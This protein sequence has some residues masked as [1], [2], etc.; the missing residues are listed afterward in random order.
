MRPLEIPIEMPFDEVIAQIKKFRSEAKDATGEVAGGLE[1][2][3][4]ATGGA[5]RGVG[6]LIEG[7]AGFEMVKEGL[8]LVSEVAAEIGES[9]NKAAEF[10]RKCAEEFIQVQKGMQGIAA[11]SGRQ[12][13]DKFTMEQ[14]EKA[15]AAHLTPQEFAKSEE[16][17]LERSRANIG[18]GPGARMTEEEADKYHARMAEFAKLNKVDAGTMAEFA[19][20]LLNQQKGPVTADELTAQ[21]GKVFETLRGSG[22][23]I[24]AG[25]TSLNRLM[26]QGV[27]AQ[28][29]A[30]ALAQMGQIGLGRNDAQTYMS[31]LNDIR[32]LETD[33]KKFGEAR[34]FGV[35]KGMSDTDKVEAVVRTLSGKT[36]GG[37]DTDKLNKLLAEITPDRMG[38]NVLRAMVQKGPENLSKFKDIYAATP[39]DA[40]QKA[41]EAGRESSAGKVMETEAHLAAAREGQG[42]KYAGVHD[43]KKEAEAQLTKEGVFS[44]THIVD[45]FMRR[46]LTVPGGEEDVDKQRIN[47][48]AL[49]LAQ[50]QAGVKTVLPNGQQA[51]DAD[52]GVMRGSNTK[53]YDEA[54]RALLM[55]SNEH[56][57]AI[58]GAVKQPAMSAP[59]AGGAN[60]RQAH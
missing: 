17:F 23:S 46:R 34:K 33:Q 12:N 5:E 54:I 20:S 4:D 38:Q 52:S 11:M 15:D 48:R 8:H 21:A 2:V 25:V 56:L 47:E 43:L 51:F 60:M 29:A 1:K 59:P 13:T 35:E 3:A 24:G 50:E 37:A 44:Q 16:A 53:V 18:A 40:V 42:A 26:A 32:R 55:K 22:K 41:I 6:A 39:G 9:M 57:G 31:V 19:G 10:T 7:F 27:E 45:D 36:G 58:A 28:E 14:I 49:K 30:P